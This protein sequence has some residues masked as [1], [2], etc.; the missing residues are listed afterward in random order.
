MSASEPPPGRPPA[1]IDIRAS[2]TL[3]KLRFNVVPATRMT[4]DGFPDHVSESH[5][6]RENLPDRVREGVTY[7]DVTV[8]WRASAR[9]AHPTDSEA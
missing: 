4:F 9:V 2:A 1:D 8:R 6:E 3:R 7:N 5:T